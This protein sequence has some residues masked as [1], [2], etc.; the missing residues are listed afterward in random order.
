MKRTYRGTRYA[1]YIGFVTQAIINNLAPLL[2]I[3]FQ[4]RFGVT[5]AEISMLV[6]ANFVTQLAVDVIAMKTVDRIGHRLSLVV[7]HLFSGVG[8]VLM[9]LA[10][11]MA[12]NPF[13]LL[14]VS[15]ILYAV[16]GGLTEVLISPTVEN[17][18]GD[19]KASAMSL[20][21]SFYC[22]GQM[23]VV[24]VSTVVLNFIG[25]DYWWTLPIGWSLVPF[26]NAINFMTVP[27]VPPPAAGE[28]GMK[29]RELLSSPFFLVALVLMMCAGAS[30]LA[31]SQWAS[32]FAE[33]SLG[34]SKMMGDLLGP[35]MFALVM[36][37]GRTF[38][39]IYGDRI[40]M[41]PALTGCAALCVVS[42][43]LTA[44]SPIPILSLVGCSL[45]G[46]SVALMWPGTFSLTSATYPRG[47]TALF[48]MLA[49]FGDLGCASGPWL[50]GMMSDLAEATASIQ[51]DSLKF[52]VLMGTFF[53]LLMLVLLLVTRKKAKSKQPQ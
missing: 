15:V 20:L 13:G 12:D 4:T 35:C 6:M 14:M 47:G 28:K 8:L 48:A 36:G 46:L 29:L 3:I 40:R 11:Q 39:G 33:T 7:A 34:I 27:I 17:L 18:P 31:M 52:G 30:E 53:P 9:G 22:W 26:L 38:F 50:A 10:P 41:R 51:M 24:L 2:F 21:H 42:Y 44:L 25:A 45:C 1:C 37:L 23:V 5:Y 19:G 32:L 16:G 49:V 43:L